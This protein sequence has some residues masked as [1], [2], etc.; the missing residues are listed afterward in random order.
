LTISYHLLE[1]INTFVTYQ[2]NHRPITYACTWANS[3]RYCHP[4]SQIA[5]GNVTPE[6][7]LL[8]SSHDRCRKRS[9]ILTKM[10]SRWLWL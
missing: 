8:D 2:T 4:A 3:M 7:T 5:M 6:F 9:R 10:T 1:L